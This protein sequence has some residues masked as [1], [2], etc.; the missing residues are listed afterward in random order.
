MYRFS[1][2]LV[3]VFSLSSLVAAGESDSQKTLEWK[4][5]A[6]SAKITPAKPL[7]MAGYAGRKEPAEG[8]EQDLYAKALAVEDQQGNRVVF[9]TLDLIG[10]I[11][12][13]RSDVTSQVQEKF[14]VPP[15]AVL[16][17]ASHTHCGPA[18]G[19]DDAQEY[20][21]QLSA[22]LVKT[23][24]QAIE[25]L[26]P[27]QLSWSAA[28]CSVAMNRRTP[29]ATGYRN[30]PNPEGRVDHQVP[31]LRVDDPQ[32]N[33]KAVMFGYACHNTTMGF[34]KWLGDYAGFA[35]E[36]FEKD[37]PGVTALFMM[38]CGGDQNPYPRS[39][40]HYA[41]KHG[42]S[43]ATAVE[44]ALEVN[45]RTMLHQHKLHG[46]L[47]VAYG[48]VELEYLPEKKREPWD[49]PVQVIQF[50]NDLTMVALGT[51]VVVDYA[52]RIKQELYEE[53]GPAIWV[54][55]YSNVYSG[56]I[57]SKRVLLEGG[58]E[59]SRPYKPDVEE[60]IIGKVLELNESLH[61]TGSK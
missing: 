34:R 25:N 2:C 56:Y 4:A 9:L 32:G 60:R 15:A 42:R 47:K 13:L 39:E 44:A 61:T 6:A 45:Q 41:H 29:T 14:K 24:G 21:D 57:P 5:G 30:H 22:T 19:R 1:L 37:H 11:D 8:T 10:V 3:F 12:R 51:E 27:A 26:E 59:A 52:L 16:M 50:G 36:Y 55:G 18:Y 43:L 31:V 58:Y 54:A 35:Q 7:K 17:N 49:Y 28:R 53:D 38:G 48:T 20:Y 40:L 46:P 33:L 23:I